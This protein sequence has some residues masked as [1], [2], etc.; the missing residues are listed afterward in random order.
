MR[1]VQIKTKR[2]SGG[3]TYILLVTRHIEKIVTIKERRA[4]TTF[5]LRN[6]ALM[7]GKT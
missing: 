4:G 2:R 5:P 3:L 6:H 1:P 7:N